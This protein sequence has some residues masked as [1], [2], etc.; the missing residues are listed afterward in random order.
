MLRIFRLVVATVVA[1]VPI[2]SP[3]A[4]A[5]D[6][7]DGYENILFCGELNGDCEVSSSDALVAL[8]IGVG[9][10]DPV[11]EAD[12]NHSGTVT[13]GDALDVLRL[14]VGSSFKFYECDNQYSTKASFVATFA[15]NGSRTSGNYAVGWYQPPGAE[16]RNMLVFD[17]SGIP[18]TIDSAL[19]HLAT[20]PNGQPFYPNPSASETF[21]LYEVTTDIQTMT[22][23]FPGAAGFD[24][25]GA[26]TIFGSV[27]AVNGQ[28][29]PVIDVP[30]TGPAVAYLNDAT[31][32]VAFGGAITTLMKA[33]ENEYLFN[34]TGATNV[35]ELIVRV[36]E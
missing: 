26:G 24:D 12:L 30:L 31:G 19:L 10:V 1:S 18:G 9:L 6:V 17:V 20:A 8:R 28:V 32:E 27:V 23:G 2:V 25:L 34:Q 35:R 13:A 15:S 7:C 33:A 16:L 21:T 22:V 14:A 36:E 3:H 29:G 5:G 4:H 11:A